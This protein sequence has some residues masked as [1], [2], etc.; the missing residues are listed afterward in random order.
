MLAAAAVAAAACGIV[1]VPPYVS[2]NMVLQTN[3]M[4]GARGFVDGWAD[5]GESI[6]IDVKYSATHTEQFYTTADSSGRWHAQLNPKKKGTTATITVRGATNS[7]VANNAVWGDV[8][9][10]SG[11]SNMVKPVSYDLNA[12]AEIAAASHYS[13]IR[14]FTVPMTTADTEQEHLPNGTKG[15]QLNSNTTLPN[16]SAVCYLTARHLVDDYLGRDFPVGLIFSAWGGTPVEAWMSAAS[17]T[18]CPSAGLGGPQTNSVLYNAMIHPLRSVSIRAMLWDQGEANVAGRNDTAEQYACRFGA[19]I[20]DWRDRFG[21]GDW[22]SV[23]VQLSP[24]GNGVGVGSVTHIR[25]AQ[26]MVEPAPG[27]T[28]DTTGMAVTIDLGDAKGGVHTRHKEEVARRLALKMRHVAYAQQDPDVHHSG[29]VAKSAAVKSAEGK[30]NVTI[31][32]DVDKVS[33]GDTID[34]TEC[35]KGDTRMLQLCTTVDATTCIPAAAGSLVVGA[36]TLTA[37]FAALPG[38]ASP[39]TVL[40][41]GTDFPQCALYDTQ[42]L[43][44]G[45]ALLHLTT[46]SGPIEQAAGAEGGAEAPVKVGTVPPMGFNS[47]NAFHNNVDERL[48][49]RTA[50]L[51][52]SLGLRDVGFKYINIDDGWQV[53]RQPD[54]AITPDPVR[55]PSGMKALA[56]YVHSKGLLF[57]LY[58]AQ[59]QFTCQKR[60]G[61][62]N[63][64]A[65]D[66]ATYCSWGIDYIKID[67][68]GGDHWPQL[69]TSWIKFREGITKCEEGGGRPIFMSTEYC[70]T[71]SGCG[72]WIP[73]LSNSWR[74]GGDIQANW[75]SVMSNLDQT[76]PLYPLAGPDG[77]YGGHWNDA[78]MLQ[79]GNI[80]LSE[81]EQQAHF[82][83]WVL[84]NSPLLLGTDLARI[85]NATLQIITNKEVTDISQDALG[86]Q[87]RRPLG[88]GDQE[89]WVKQLSGGAVALGLL[90]RGSAAANI[91]AD[92]S[93]LGICGSGCAVRDLWAHKDLGSH[94]GSYSTSVPSHGLALLRLS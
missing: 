58:T 37:S 19:M 76:E 94:S 46:P 92:F 32:F 40:F 29:P 90:N 91:T 31:R 10:C 59:K 12:S 14:L 67:Q 75:A 50:D 21:T 5:A 49:R 39:R 44:S 38:G 84:L 17:L 20:N 51:F 7:I 34:C 89:V 42:S 53:L 41:M 88:R 68:C 66:A 26:S 18:R 28:V 25:L 27:R 43:P 52:V 87:A 9:L 54:G 15:W 3:T 13:N 6:T 47:W 69:N 57:G 61:S 93:K 77:P 45:P 30:Y 65:I 8:F 11:Q 63:H 78:D 2:D 73:A 55:F 74:T 83:L 62:Y 72:E 4:Y 16:F 23:F 56:D 85:S 79:V 60:P 36:G 71:L 64:E 33:L 24:Y 1:T 80:G 35:C 81:I 48:I 86:Y 70:G 22:A 82:G